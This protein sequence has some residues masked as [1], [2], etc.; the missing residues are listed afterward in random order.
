MEYGLAIMP[1]AVK[2]LAR[3][4]P[5]MRRRIDTALQRLR[6][7]LAGDVKHLSGHDPKYR[8]RV[9]SYRVLFNIES[10]TIII[11]DIVDRKDAY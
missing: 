5:P 7:D 9:G 8:L 2:Q 1:R 11:H 3:T 4:P 6:H 10:G